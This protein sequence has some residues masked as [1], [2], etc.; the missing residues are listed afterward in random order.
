M[1]WRNI[2]DGNR[3]TR[4][5]SRCIRWISTGMTTAPRPTKNAGVRKDIGF[6]LEG[7]DSAWEPLSSH[8]HQPLAA[9]QIA[10]ER[11]VERLGRVRQRVVDAVLGE[12]RG[13]RVRMRRDQRAVLVAE[14]FGHDRELFARL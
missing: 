3:T 12:L 11:V 8:S 2:S 1:R 7:P 14:R 5:R 9:R 6:G 13:Q 4:F 10:E